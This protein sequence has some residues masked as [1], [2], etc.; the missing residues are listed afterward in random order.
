M[1]FVAKM[2]TIGAISLVASGCQIRGIKD[3]PLGH[4]CYRTF[5]YDATPR[6]YGCLFE[7]TAPS[8]FYDD[9]AMDRVVYRFMKQEGGICTRGPER[10]V[11]DVRTQAM[12]HGL[13]YRLFNVECR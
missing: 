7:L 5:H 3:I 12:D 1:K 4:A 11:A 13:R 2:L 9:Q 6:V 10:D 8:S